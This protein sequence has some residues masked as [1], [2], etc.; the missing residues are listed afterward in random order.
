MLV[1]RWGIENWG[2]EIRMDKSMS[3]NAVGLYLNS[4]AV[5]EF[6]RRYDEHS[7]DGL[8]ADGSMGEGLNSLP[9]W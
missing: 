5:T 9:A 1:N 8:I 7:V 3:L 4:I 6:I 2:V